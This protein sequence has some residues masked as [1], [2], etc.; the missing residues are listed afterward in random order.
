M[1]QL[2]S[3]RTRVTSHSTLVFSLG[4]PA[5]GVIMLA[6]SWDQ[7]LGVVF[8]GA[9]A[10]VSP[11]ALYSALIVS[12]ALLAFLAISLFTLA[13]LKR[14]EVVGETVVVRG[15]ISKV[16][17]AKKDVSSVEVLHSHSSDRATAYRMS[18]VGRGGRTKSF[19]FVPREGLADESLHRLLR[20]S[21]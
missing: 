3:V 20:P 13:P 14:I 17:Y 8:D 7:G 2:N 5:L 11:E 9:E 19:V 10:R 18:V 16:S 15:L 1:D 12:A 6:A 4:F 21:P